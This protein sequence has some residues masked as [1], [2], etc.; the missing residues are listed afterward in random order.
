M[1]YS[2][3][4]LGSWKERQSFYSSTLLTHCG[5]GK[6]LRKLH[7][8]KT[9][10]KEYKTQ[11]SIRAHI[12]FSKCQVEPMGWAL[13]TPGR[14]FGLINFPHQDAVLKIPSLLL[15]SPTKNTHRKPNNCS[16]LHANAWISMSFWL[17][18]TEN[19]HLALLLYYTCQ[20]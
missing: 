4:I 8:N 17:N 2:V 15:Y 18:S 13:G 10:S 6:F 3:Y 9:T 16:L 14:D 5:T 7:Q 12:H 20:L 1:S 11:I 19:S